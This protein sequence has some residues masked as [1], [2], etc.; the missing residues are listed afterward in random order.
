MNVVDE[1]LARRNCG[2]VHCGISSKAH[3]ALADLARE[4]GLADDPA[5]YRQIDSAAARRLLERI[6]HQ[7][8]AY[9]S[10]VMP[11]DEASD[12]AGRFMAYFETVDTLYYTNGTFHELQRNGTSWNPVTEATFD[13]GVLAISAERA[14]CLW[15]EDED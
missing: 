2:S 1:I 13:T 9:D 10:E 5:L 6:L 8:L 15:V 12:L 11:I 3:P 14:G 7:D 4:F